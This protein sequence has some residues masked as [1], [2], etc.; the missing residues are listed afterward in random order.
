MNAQ[1]ERRITMM[2]VDT[3]RPAPFNPPVRTTAQ[4]IL[5]LKKSVEEVGIIYPL[6]VNEKNVLIDGHRRLACAKALNMKSVPVIMV[7]G[8]TKRVFDEVNRTPRKLGTRDALFIFLAGGPVSAEAKR[9]I[10]WL[11]ELIGEDDL[12][13]AAE[14]RLSAKSIRNVLYVLRGYIGEQSPQFWKKAARWIIYNRQ[15]FAVRVAVQS[16]MDVRTII[17]CIEANAPVG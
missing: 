8:D 7:H 9:D 4:A 6:L 13:Y 11:K 16:G 17:G 15:Q 2:D 3:I 14:N 5:D 10:L 1:T 12:Q